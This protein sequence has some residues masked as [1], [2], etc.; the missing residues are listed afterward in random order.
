LQVTLSASV[1]VQ[2]ELSA[3]VFVQVA[4]SPL[5]LASCIVS[6]DS[7]KLHCLPPKWSTA[8]KSSE[9]AQMISRCLKF[10]KISPP[11]SLPVKGRFQRLESI[12]DP[13]S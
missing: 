4:L 9:K 7:G 8:G 2:V 1:F 12:D 11:E 5:I 6:F 10:S 13:I 3:S